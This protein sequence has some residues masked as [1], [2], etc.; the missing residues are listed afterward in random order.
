[1]SVSKTKL[2]A[3]PAAIFGMLVVYCLK[4]VS[5]LAAPYRL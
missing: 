3:L 2:A 4:S 5:V 1:M